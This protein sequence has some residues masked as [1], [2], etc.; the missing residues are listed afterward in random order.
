ML[1]NELQEI[2]DRI[3]SRKN[4][5]N[6]VFSFIA[7]FLS[8]VSSFLTIELIGF[9][10]IISW[11]LVFLFY[12]LLICAMI[13]SGVTIVS[14]LISLRTSRNSKTYF[15]V[16]ICILVLVIVIKEIFQRLWPYK[17]VEKYFFQ[18]CVCSQLHEITCTSITNITLIKFAYYFDAQGNRIG[19]VQTFS[20]TDN[21]AFTWYSRDALGNIICQID[22]S[23]KE[24]KHHE[25]L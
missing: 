17:R 10:R 24:V 14:C 20:N 8:S 3:R 25:E 18:G 15:A 5:R 9:N 23:T 12:G 21:R 11:T 1:E 19:K 7:L 13:I 2:N 16:C 6:A 22:R 4:L